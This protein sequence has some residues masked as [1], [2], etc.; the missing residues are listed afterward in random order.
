METDFTEI[1]KQIKDIVKIC[2][3]I[4]ETYREKCFGYLIENFLLKK[5][6]N[7]GPQIIPGN[8]SEETIPLS[9]DVRAFLSQYSLNEGVIGKLFLMQQGEIRHI[10]K[11]STTIKS[12]AQIQVA[13]LI[14]LENTIKD[15][16]KKFEFS[17]EEVRQRCIDLQVYDVKNYA[18][19]FKANEKFFKS[20]DDLEHIV[21]SSDGKAELAETI[22]RMINEQ[23]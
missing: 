22:N 16:N 4:P 13:L 9:I 2:E 18:R 7:E 12:Q 6:G 3:D 17:S 21:L 5:S 8:K 23:G 15:P 1:E 19:H 20:L 14:A 10:Y 11:I